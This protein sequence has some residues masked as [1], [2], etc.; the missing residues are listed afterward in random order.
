MAAQ[1]RYRPAP[2][3]AIDVSLIVGRDDPHVGAAQLAGWRDECVAPPACHW[4]DGGHI[5]FDR[6]PSAVTGLL[7]EVVRADQHVEMI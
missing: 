1:Y 6:R 2:P 7:R 4:A 5:Y 3:L